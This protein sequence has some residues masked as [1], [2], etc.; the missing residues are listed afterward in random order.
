MVEEN[1]TEGEAMTEG[2]TMTEGQKETEMVVR[3]FRV[4]ETEQGYRIEINGDKDEIRNSGLL[5][6]ITG[7]GSRMGRHGHGR[8]RRG[9]RRHMM[10]ARAMHDEA[11]RGWHG[12][13]RRGYG[14]RDY[15]WYP[16]PY[17][18]EVAEQ[19]DAATDSPA[20]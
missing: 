10:R 14:W 17:E 8:D 4:I 19:G 15:G 3:E 12:Y 11:V 5:G 7:M 2:E 9:F 1:V 18:G 13:G 16:D 20:V 6:L